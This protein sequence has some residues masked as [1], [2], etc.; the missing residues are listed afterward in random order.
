MMERQAG[1]FKGRREIAM[2]DEQARED[3]LRRA[4]RRQGLAIQKSRARNPRHVCCGLWRIID[5]ST[6][7][8][9]IGAGVLDY[10]MELDDVEAWLN[11][12]DEER[13]SSGEEEI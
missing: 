7:T 6:N 12:S 8:V 2:D 10:E 5:P 13:A 4:A 1:P 9:V 11:A 3:R